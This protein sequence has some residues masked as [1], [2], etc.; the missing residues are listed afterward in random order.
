MPVRKESWLIYTLLRK[1]DDLTY[2]AGCDGRD[3]AGQNC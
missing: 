2:L 1:R 3:G